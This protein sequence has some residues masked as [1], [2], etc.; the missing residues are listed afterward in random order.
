MIEKESFLKRIT[1]RYWVIVAIC[2]GACTLTQFIDIDFI[3]T[4]IVLF[5]VVSLGGFILMIFGIVGALKSLNVN[6]DDDCPHADTFLFVTPFAILLYL[7]SWFITVMF[8]DMSLGYAGQ[9]IGVNCPDLSISGDGRIISGIPR[10]VCDKQEAL[11][12]I[13]GAMGGMLIAMGVALLER[14]THI[15]KRKFEHRINIEKQNSELLEKER[16]RSRFNCAVV[17]LASAW[18]SQRIA[19]F[20]LFYDLAK[21]IQ[22]HDDFNQYACDILCVHLREMFAQPNISSDECR[23]L[24]EILC[25]LKNESD[26]TYSVINNSNMDDINY[27]TAI[28]I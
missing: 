12:F 27:L 15:A 1:C 11:N 24:E 25:K 5:R 7:T 19:S 18:S 17:N 9:L 26:I 16:I 22:Q 14:R 20:Y 4:H 6:F 10:I 21:D 23:I 8:S 28:R 2:G 3:K 13:G